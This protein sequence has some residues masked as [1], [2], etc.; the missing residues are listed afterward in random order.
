M[1]NNTI[2][3]YSSESALQRAFIK[4]LQKTLNSNQ[5]E[6]LESLKIEIE[7]YIKLK[8]SKQKKLSPNDIIGV[9]I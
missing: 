4:A 3:E 2:T 7:N 5:A 6:T 9:N 1:N 8:N